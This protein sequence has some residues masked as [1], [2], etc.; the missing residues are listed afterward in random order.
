M[1]SQRRCLARQLLSTVTLARQCSAVKRAMRKSINHVDSKKTHW[2]LETVTP[3]PLNGRGN[4]LPSKAGKEPGF[5]AFLS[6]KRKIPEFTCN[7]TEWRHLTS[8]GVQRP[9]NP[10][11]RPARVWASS[12]VSPGAYTNTLFTRHAG[13]YSNTAGDC[14][15]LWDITTASW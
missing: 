9:L 5:S 2:V 6:R 15:E 4:P 1:F 7:A 10:G 3:V 13:W 8:S 11:A 12:V 14:G